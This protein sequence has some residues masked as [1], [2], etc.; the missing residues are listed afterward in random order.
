MYL[1]FKVSKDCPIVWLEKGTFAPK[2]YQQS[3]KLRDSAAVEELEKRVL[4]AA[5]STLH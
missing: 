4:E 1:K 2:R 5:S 3:T